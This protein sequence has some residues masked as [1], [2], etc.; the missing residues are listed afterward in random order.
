MRNFT[1][2]ALVLCF[3]LPAA[4]QKA[5]ALKKAGHPVKKAHAVAVSTAAPAVA[6]VIQRIA[7]LLGVPNVAP[8]TKL[9]S[10]A[11]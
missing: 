11:P 6:R 9:A 5:P 4:A 10:G 8:P 2:I 7:P 3:A 1:V